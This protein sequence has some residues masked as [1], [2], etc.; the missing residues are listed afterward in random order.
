MSEENE[1]ENTIEESEEPET[2]VTTEE[3]E[4]EEATEAEETLEADTTEDID[5]EV[6]EDIAALL[7][8]EQEEVL[9]EVSA[10]ETEEEDELEDEED[11][12]EEE[13]E[14]PD[15][16]LDVETE[17]DEL[18]IPDIPI[19]A[20]E[21]E[22]TEEIEAEPIEE[23]L[24]EEEEKE[25]VDIDD[26]GFEPEEVK[27]IKKAKKSRAFLW[28]FL[29]GLA[30]AIIIE[31]AFS[32]PIWL[33]G[34][35][36]PDLY[37]IEL[38]LI[39]V[40]LM[41]PGLFTRS[42]QKGILGA[43]IIFIIS[44][45]VPLVLSAFNLNYILNPLTPLFSSTD[46]ALD[47]YDVFS[48]LFQGLE[49]VPIAQIQ[50]WIWIVDLVL[51]FILTVIV[52][53]FATWLLKNITIKKKKVGHWI[54][55]PLLSIALIVFGIFT[56][57]LFSSTYGIINA[58]TSF[59]AGATKMQE[60]Y[61]VF[62]TGEDFGTQQLD[63]ID[64]VLVEANY[65]MNISSEN[66]EGLRN[67]GIINFAI[68]ASGRYGPLIEAGDQLA[69]S[70]L[71]LSQI[72]VP[73]FNGLYNLTDSLNTATDSLSN[74]GTSPSLMLSDTGPYTFEKQDISDIETLTADILAAVQGLEAA[75]AA[76]EIVKAK[77]E[78]AEIEG[79]FSDIADTLSEL[80]TESMQL[81]SIGDVVQEIINT[82]DTFDDQLAGFIDFVYY[83]ADS[84]GP[85]KHLLWVSYNS[86]VGNEYLRYNRF[87][88]AKNSFQYAI[89]NISAIDS[90]ATYTPDPALGEIFSVQ[91]TDGFA[92]MLNDLLDLMEPLLNEKFYYAETFERIS[93][94]MEAFASEPDM[95]T[96]DYGSIV[97]PTASAAVMH[98]FS[99]ATNT[100][101]TAFRAN[102]Q[103]GIYGSI[104]DDIGSNFE[105]ILSEDF[106]PI[107]FSHMTGDLSLVV[108]NFV[109]GCQA[110]TASDF[111]FAQANLTF[112]EDTM[113]NDITPMI[114]ADDPTYLKNYLGNWTLAMTNIQ[115]KMETL[116]TYASIQIDI[117][118]L[119]IAT[120]ER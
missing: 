53:T 26:Y 49:N 65:W 51:M 16:P 25:D 43:F 72:L 17:A 104:F 78:D 23:V 59:L 58:S 21:E 91:V 114:I 44:F 84:L 42:M 113:I 90:L 28:G 64:E 39:L 27:A 116:D 56:P 50:K 1:N 106:R 20:K 71:A 19:E 6:E 33:G 109:L 52:V 107:E 15:I 94:I 89:D 11:T 97:V 96:L 111:A 99:V 120:Q 68:L 18:E 10:E 7:E 93:L 73:L 47:A 117:D 8:E 118:N 87:T 76:M 77:L 66:Y 88:D 81:F 9:D 46:F 57:I 40:A 112:A 41:I 34:V 105:E 13:L 110:Y 74:F 2:L 35:G 115:N 38:V 75:E 85:T 12:T 69:L 83:V 36:R 37:Y 80:D 32:I 31:V 95:T 67:I 29:I 79:T 24:S 86:I 14:I 3:D 82:I 4:D 119:Y 98:S 60:A 108:T 48:G 103:L 92:T 5:E 62:S 101:L 30:A 100:S 45:A 70:T 54:G 22:L 61:D 55:I 102:V 63:A